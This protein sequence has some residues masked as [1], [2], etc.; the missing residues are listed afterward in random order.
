MSG[1]LHDVRVLDLTTVILGPL[2]T[3]ILGDLGAEI[4]KVEP[5]EGDSNRHLGTGRNPGMSGTVMNLHRNKR[6]IVLDLKKRAGR[7]ALLRLAAGADVLV[8]NIR[9]AAMERLGLG[10]PELKMANPRLI[11]CAAT[12][13]GSGGPYADRPAY[14]DLIQGASG[15]SDLLGRVSG[16]PGMVPSIVC[17]KITGLTAVYAILAALFHRERTGEGQMVEVPM[18]ETMAA[19]NL[20]EHYAGGVFRPP[21]GP[22]G[23]SRLLTPYR[24][25]YRCADGYL[26]L[27]AYTDRQWRGFFE[28]IGRPEL[29]DDERF[30][31]LA[32][33]TR[34]TD[35]LYAIVEQAIADK[36]TAEW[37]ELCRRHQIPCMP[38]LKIDEIE[39]DP[40]LAE[41]GFFGEAEHPSEG[42]YTQVGI[43]TRFSASRTQV[44]RHAPALGEHSVEILRE[45]GFSPA[46]I[47]ALL[48]EGASIDGR[49][50]AAEAA[51]DSQA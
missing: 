17:D 23:Y 12:G 4:V 38:L 47:A 8:H 3:Q 26:C 21:A 1:P 11:Y 30:R 9:L 49:P 33:R 50:V 41:T 14:D 5:P 35:A 24:K 48:D 31:T 37:L 40:H 22:I 13:F 32:A 19:F 6:S 51:E 39:R 29:A 44:R 2:A 36:T 34:N 45:A 25:P 20:V 42:R 27:L 28:I 43:P 16:A 46:E 10:W 18:L 15:L 7:E